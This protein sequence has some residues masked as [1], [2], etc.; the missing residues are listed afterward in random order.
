MEAHRRFVSDRLR[1]GKTLA[2]HNAP[3]DVPVITGQ[4]RALRLMVPIEV[5]LD[6]PGALVRHGPLPPPSAPELPIS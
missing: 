6:D 2:H 1:A 5:E 3:H 4:E